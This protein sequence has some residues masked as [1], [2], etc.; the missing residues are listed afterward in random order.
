MGPNN[1]RSLSEFALIL[2]GFINGGTGKLLSHID[3]SLDVLGGH[4]DGSGLEE[5]SRWF[6]GEGLKVAKIYPSL[7][8]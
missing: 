1:Q 3:S 2:P 5:P 8:Y 7:V 6:F 4:S